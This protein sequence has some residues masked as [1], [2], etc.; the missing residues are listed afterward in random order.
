MGCK[1]KLDVGLS[2]ET[3]VIGAGMLMDD[4]ENIYSFF[5]S[6][7]ADSQCFGTSG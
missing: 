3:I 1:V 6:G 4:Y 5:D 2:N 7:T